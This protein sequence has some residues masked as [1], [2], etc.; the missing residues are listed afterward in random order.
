M[1][2]NLSDTI[3]VLLVLAAFARA[4]ICTRLLSPNS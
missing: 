2:I 1:P 4:A 3:I